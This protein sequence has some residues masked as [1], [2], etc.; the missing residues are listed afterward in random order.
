MKREEKETKEKAV[1]LNH[2]ST[3]INTQV[4]LRMY[5]TVQL[6]IQKFHA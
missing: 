1:C 4:K 3:Q 2:Q 5:I 6:M